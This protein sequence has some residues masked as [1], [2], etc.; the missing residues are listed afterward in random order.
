MTLGRG[1]GGIGALSVDMRPY[2]LFI[3]GAIVK[4]QIYMP[5][6]IYIFW[7]SSDFCGV[8]GRYKVPKISTDKTVQSFLTLY[9]TTSLQRLFVGPFES[10]FFLIFFAGDNVAIL[11]SHWYSLFWTLVDSAHGN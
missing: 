10:F 3:L 8:Q 11:W 7:R 5:Q 4:T 6:T 2:G 9:I 1:G